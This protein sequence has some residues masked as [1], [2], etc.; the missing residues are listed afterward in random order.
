MAHEQLKLENQLCFRFYT[1]SRLI[2]QAYRPYLDRLGITYPQYLV[3]MV[4]WEKDSQPVNDIAQ[5]LHLETNTAT[6]LIQR[7]EREG[8]VTKAK[9][10][11]D[12]RQTIVS[13]TEKGKVMEAE[14]AD[15][16]SCMGNDFVKCDLD[17]DNLASLIPVLDNLIEK[18]A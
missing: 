12:G 4:L 17:V 6:P 13:L 1:A 3:L 10:A 8:I 11:K 16:P 7:M 2:T 15:I 14:A 18:L 5:R 9:N